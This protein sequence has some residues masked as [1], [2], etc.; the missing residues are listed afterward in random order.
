MS[1]NFSVS[2]PAHNDLII[3]KK[4]AL[5]VCSITTSLSSNKSEEAENLK[6][7]QQ[8]ENGSHGVYCMP[9]S[10]SHLYQTQT[11]LI[12]HSFIWT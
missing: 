8:N 7:W 1:C 9:L 5:H 12:L 2:F 3:L 6:I 11:L 10:E 4:V